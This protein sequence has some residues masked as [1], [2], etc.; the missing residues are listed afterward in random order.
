MG[1]SQIP[2]TGFSHRP[3]SSQR[4]FLTS[5]GVTAVASQAT[6]GSL[7]SRLN[8]CSAVLANDLL[9]NHNIKSV[10]HCFLC[11]HM[12]N[13]TWKHS[14]FSFNSDGY[15]VNPT[16]IIITLDKERQWDKVRPARELE[17]VWS[18]AGVFPPTSLSMCQNTASVIS[19]VV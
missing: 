10:S 18:N 8:I 17:F 9:I 1:L 3:F 7:H 6:V 15:L 13:V 4:A 16:I 11:R 2:R 12:L 14:D 5:A 19:H